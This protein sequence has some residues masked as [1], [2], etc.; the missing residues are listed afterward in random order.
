MVLARHAHPDLLQSVAGIVFFGTPFHGIEGALGNGRIEEYVRSHGDPVKGDIL[1]VL[2][3]TNHDLNDTLHD[4]TRIATDAV[5][6]PTIVC[7]YEQKASKVWAIAGD[8]DAQ[9][10]GGLLS[11]FG[12]RSTK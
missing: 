5:R 3:P 1:S 8:R 12:F 2:R 11:S 10:V 7:F 9:E 6:L 4:F